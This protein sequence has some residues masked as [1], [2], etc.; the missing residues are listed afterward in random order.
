MTEPKLIGYK[1]RYSHKDLKLFN[2]N[3]YY[4][5]LYNEHALTAMNRMKSFVDPVC[6]QVADTIITHSRM[7]ESAVN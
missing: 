2:H 1:L 5:R 7:A 3:N 4:R 6:L